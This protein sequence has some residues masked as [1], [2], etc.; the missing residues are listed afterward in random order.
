MNATRTEHPLPAVKR[1]AAD[2]FQNNR[3]RLHPPKSSCPFV[4]KPFDGRTDAKDFA[5]EWHEFRVKR[6]S[7]VRKSDIQRR[8]DL[9]IGFHPHQVAR[10]KT[11]IAPG[12]GL[13]DRGRSL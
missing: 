1:F 8:E 5:A 7:S 3:R 6:E 4:Y 2:A 11:E 10:L 13:P 12:C 9:F